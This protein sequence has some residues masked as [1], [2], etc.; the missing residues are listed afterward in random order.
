ML[1]TGFVFHNRPMYTVTSISSHLPPCQPLGTFL[2]LLLPWRLPEEQALKPLL[3][4]GIL[5][6]SVI[7]SLLL[8]DSTYAF[9]NYQ[10]QLIHINRRKTNSVI[11]LILN[12]KAFKRI[13]C[14]NIS[15]TNSEGYFQIT[16]VP[17]STVLLCY[18]K[19]EVI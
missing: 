10:P 13:F 11:A 8:L 6:S 19:Y 15:L 9:Q 12:Q 1:G 4:S 18:F 2:H 14:W 17:I 5:H 16:Y 3:A 7:T